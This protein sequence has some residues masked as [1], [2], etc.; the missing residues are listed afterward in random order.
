MF[1]VVSVGWKVFDSDSNLREEQ[2]M[3]WNMDWKLEA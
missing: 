3:K 1:W 2:R